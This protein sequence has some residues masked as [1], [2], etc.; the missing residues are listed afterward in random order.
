MG[1]LGLFVDRQTMGNSEQLT[2]LI[3]LRDSAEVMGHSVYFIFPTEIAK[4]E[5]VDAS[6][7]G[8]GPTR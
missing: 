6:S 4:I 3:R 7:S 2:S 1:K 5:K 8:A